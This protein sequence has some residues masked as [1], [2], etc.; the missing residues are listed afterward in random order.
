LRLAPLLCLRSRAGE[1]NDVRYTDKATGRVIKR[2]HGSEEGRLQVRLWHAVRWRRRRYCSRAATAKTCAVMQPALCAK[3]RIALSTVC[4]P[5]CCTLHTAAPQ[6]PS[7]ELLTLLASLDLAVTCEVLVGNFD[8]EVSQAVFAQMCYE[9][10]DVCPRAYSL[11]TGAVKVGR[12]CVAGPGCETSNESGWVCGR[13]VRGSHMGA[14][15]RRQYAATRWALDGA[16]AGVALAPLLASLV[17][18]WVDGTAD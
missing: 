6:D 2:G 5:H 3:N 13:C 4:L 1:P 16:L 8:S 10:Q 9:N 18:A 17:L 11:G 15:V 12:K 14:A 7:E